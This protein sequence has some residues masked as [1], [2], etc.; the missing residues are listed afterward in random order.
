MKYKQVEIKEN[1][2]EDLIRLNSDLIEPGLKYID[3]QKT[4][5]K[6]RMDVLLVDSGNSLVIA[7]LKIIEDDNMLVQAI[8]YFDF[9]NENIES[10]TRIY[11]EFNIDHSKPIRILL[12]AP[13]FSQTLISRTKWV[14]AAVSLYIYKCIQLE[15]A[16]ETIPVFNEI[17]VP[18]PK[19]I[20]EEKYNISD[21]INY[22]TDP[23]IKKLLSSFIDEL[24]SLDKESIFIEPIKYSISVK[25][26]GKVFLYISPRRD[27]FL[28]EMNDTNDKWT[29]YPINS[30]EDIDNVMD[31]VKLNM[32]KKSKK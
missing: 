5:N 11:K 10:Y 13:S 2:L 4:T 8:D 29:A 23:L 19:E 12:I 15:N 31:L 17:S 6:G 16:K 27:K 21:R 9:V 28:F 24:Q 3:H 1:E 18:T 22:V 14:N 26:N 7:E 32:S 25:I 20:L 30:R